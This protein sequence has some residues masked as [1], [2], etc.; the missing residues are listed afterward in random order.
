MTLKASGCAKNVFLKAVLN[1]GQPRDHP[2]A[3]R[4]MP[5]SSRH[6]YGM[7][8]RLIPGLHQHG[9]NCQLNFLRAFGGIIC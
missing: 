7:E 1:G 2:K 6:C 3:K 8:T 5:M 9:K 4:L